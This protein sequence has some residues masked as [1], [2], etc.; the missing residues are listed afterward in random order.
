MIARRTKLTPEP[1]FKYFLGRLLNIR[2]DEWPRLVFLYGMALVA[3]IGIG[4]GE[5]IVVAAFLHQAGVQFLPWAFVISAVASIG[6][7]FVCTGF[8][9]HVPNDKLFIWILGISGVGIVVGLALLSLRLAVGA[10]L[11]LYLI[12]SV[13]LADVYNVHWATYV[14]GYCDTRAAKRVISPY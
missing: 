4:W 1:T 3:L 8:A 9:D 6:A 14:N 11:L 13:P 7:L 2:S 10:Y 5:T 12:L